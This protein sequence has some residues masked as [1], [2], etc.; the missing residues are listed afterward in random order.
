IRRAVPAIASMPTGVIGRVAVLNVGRN[1]A[2]SALTASPLMVS[3]ALAI[4]IATVVES[5]RGSLLEWITVFAPLDL[6]IS[7]VS[8][9]LGRNV[10]LPASLG[11]EVASIPGVAVVH[12]FRLVHSMYE[13]RRIAIEAFDHDPDDPTRCC[14]RFRRGDPSTAFA[15]LATGDAVVVSENFAE[16]FDVRPGDAV[17]LPTPRGARVLQIAAVATNHNSDQGSIMMARHLFVELFGDDRVDQILVM[18]RAG[19]DIEAVRAAIAARYGKEHQL[20][21]RTNADIRRDIASRINAALMPT[22]ALFVLAVIV[23]CL[24]IANSLYVATTERT[25]EIGVLRSLGS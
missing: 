4:T 12:R 19:V 10:L 3:V 11:E 14:V 21:F 2:R 25:R 22:Y 23:G 9:Q 20:V 1:V 8:E 17:T 18:V 5:F 16:R 15:R 6:Q 24:G 13:G 7:S